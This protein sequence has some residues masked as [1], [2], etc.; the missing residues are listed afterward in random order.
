MSV[1]RIL[2]GLDATRGRRD[3]LQSHG[4]E[5]IQALKEHREAWAG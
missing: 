4:V 3:E 2:S 5:V 1:E